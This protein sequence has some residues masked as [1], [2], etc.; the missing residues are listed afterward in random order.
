M[1]VIPARSGSKGLVDKNILLLKGHPLLSYSI[2]AATSSNLVTRVIC[3]TDSHSYAEIAIK[4]G[5][6]VPFL[7]PKKYALHNSSDFEVFFQEDGRKLDILIKHPTL[8][9]AATNSLQ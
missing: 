9:Q 7:R 8:I 3:S 4:Y 1:A 2:V 5:A 6:E